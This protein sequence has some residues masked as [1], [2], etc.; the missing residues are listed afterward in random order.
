MEQTIE[1]TS[2]EAAKLLRKLNEELDNVLFMEEQSREFSAALGEDVESVRPA[3][4]YA[5]TQERIRELEE[6]IRR[7]KHAIS[8]FNLTQEVPGFGMTIDQM[9]VYIPQLSRRKAKLYGMQQCLPKQRKQA[10][11]GGGVQVIDYS[12]ANYDIERV[13]ADYERAAEELSQAQTALDLV[14]TTSKLELPA[15]LAE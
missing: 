5:T 11:Y 7:L 12:Y 1:C 10:G 15:D 13:R 8:V 14:N 3:Y 2:A 4:D 6:K 9:L